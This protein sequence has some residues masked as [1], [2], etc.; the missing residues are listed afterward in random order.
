MAVEDFCDFQETMVSSDS[1]LNIAP[2]AYLQ[3]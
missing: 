3:K 1:Y 2:G